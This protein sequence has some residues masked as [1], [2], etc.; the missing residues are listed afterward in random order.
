MKIVNNSIKT[1]LVESIMKPYHFIIKCDYK[2]KKKE[3][4]NNLCLCISC[5][6]LISFKNYKI[7]WLWLHWNLW[8]NILKWC[9]CVLTFKIKEN[10]D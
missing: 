3:R 8:N 9:T 5:L 4:Q 2:N 7:T 6:E 1:N 10:I